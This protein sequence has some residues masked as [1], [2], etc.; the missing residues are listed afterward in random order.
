MSDGAFLELPDASIY[1]EVAGEA[2]P[3]LVFAHGLG[4]SFLSWWQQVPVLSR[5]CRTVTF[6]HRGFA[7][8]TGPEGGPEPERFVAD[9]EA[10]V[11][12]LALQKFAIVA[13]SMGGWTAVGYAVRHPERVAALILAGTTGSAKAV[14]LRSLTETTQDARVVAAREAG[15]HPA[16]GERMFREQPELYYLY[17]RIDRHSGSWARDR[18]RRRLDELREDDVG[19]LARIPVL[20]LVGSEDRIC[21]PSNA[22]ILAALLPLSE[23]AVVEGAG[24]SVYF[25]RAARFNELVIDLL[26]RR[27]AG[28]EHL[29]GASGVD[30]GEERLGGKVGPQ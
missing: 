9:L 5:H 15:I 17:T 3:A 1:Y 13:Q 10:L 4:G 24:H 6:S 21:P 30:A 14:G 29:R 12:R 19:P 16:A 27:C 28:F 23:L 20:L 7:P 2:E 11:D 22:R 26:G 18:V 25:E 8:S